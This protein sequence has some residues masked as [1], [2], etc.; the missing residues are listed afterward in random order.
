VSAYNLSLSA[1]RWCQR[2]MML[3]AA[4]PVLVLAV[5]PLG[6]TGVML[7]A[8]VLL[9]FYWHWYGVLQQLQQSAAL[10]ITDNSQLHWFNSALPPGRLLPGGLVSQ[11]ML[12]LQ[13]QADTDQRCYRKWIFADQCSEAQFRALARAISQQNWQS[14]SGV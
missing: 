3:L 5:T 2:G 10:T 9:L 4:L 11:H 8:L 12:R 7:V 1:S 14:G 6:G 13:W